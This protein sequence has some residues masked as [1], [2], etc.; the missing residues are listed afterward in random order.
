MAFLCALSEPNR[1]QRFELRERE[2][3]L[4]RHPDCHVVIDVSQI[5]RHHALIKFDGKDYFVEDLGSRNFTY[6]NGKKLEPKDG[7]QRISD[8]D[9]LTICDRIFTFMA[10]DSPQPGTGVLFVD[11]DSQS[12]N[13]TIMSKVG[14]S[15]SGNSVQLS[16]SPE[17][18]LSALL[19]INRNLSR[20][21][22]L[23]EVLPTVLNSLFKIFIQADRGFIA[24]REKD[25]TLVPRW[26]RP[27]REDASET[28]RVSRTIVNQVMETQEAVLSADAA[29]DD[30]FKMS[31]SIVDFRI[32]SMMCVP[33]IDSDGQ[34]IGVVQIDTLKQNKRFQQED[35]E[36]LAAVAS[37]ASIAI[38]NAQ[39]HERVLMQ[40]L[41][42]RDLELAHEVQHSFLPDHCP[43]VGG[44]EFFD[45]Y[46]P[47]LQVGGDYFDYVVL[48]DQRVAVIVADVVGKG[49]AAALLMAKLSAEA[50]YCLASA[51]HA[52]EAITM[53]NRR[54]CRLNVDR[55]VTA[56]IA[57]L[58]PG[59]HRVEIANAGHMPPLHRDASGQVSEPGDRETGLP[60]GIRDQT[61]YQQAEIDLTRGGSL[62]L[63]TD[64]LNEAA[65]D[66]G[67]LYGVER[68]RAKVLKAT[69]LPRVL[70]QSIVDDVHQFVGQGDQSD[71]MCLVTF[72]RV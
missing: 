20:A 62:T 22:A 23:D 25:G 12:D 36:V 68:L 14:I 48:P 4:G 46:R 67:N 17:V 8:G 64:G 61:E 49:V 5:S 54:L 33:L 44:Y 72:G 6:L 59:T 71:D 55:F 24:L 27:W 51:N 18:K 9:R 66:E 26:T 52:S 10:T 30:R 41:V 69:G 50:R 58:Q 70:G 57:V 1:G 15:S 19:E 3:L 2:S 7:P 34:S 42:E 38:D 31:E 60:L 16:A 29:M 47:A 39:M 56:I 40:Q 65:D 11:D 53:L 37:Q 35:L 28:V 13:S 43:E 21:L 45:Y 32:R 63:Y